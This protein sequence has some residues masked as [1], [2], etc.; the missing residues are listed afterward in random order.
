MNKLL[1]VDLDCML[2]AAHG[3]RL[4]QVKFTG[5]GFA[6][7]ESSPSPF[8]A[9]SRRDAAVWTNSR[10]K[11]K[12]GCVRGFSRGARRR[13]QRLLAKILTDAPLPMMVALTVSDAVLEQSGLVVEPGLW[14]PEPQWKSGG[15]GEFCSQM[16]VWKDNWTKRLH[17]E[18]PQVGWLW[19]LEA[20]PR[21]SGRYK[22]LLVPHLHYLLWGV[23]F[24][25]EFVCTSRDSFF[26]RFRRGRGG[27][28]YVEPLQPGLVDDGENVIAHHYRWKAKPGHAVQVY[29]DFLCA[30]MPSHRVGEAAPDFLV[31]DEIEFREWL[32]VSWYHVVGSH[33]EQHMKAGTSCEEARSLLGAAGYVSKGAGQYVSKLGVWDAAITGRC[34]G[35]GNAA[36]IPWAQVEELKIPAALG[37]QIRRVARHYIEHQIGRKFT[38]RAGCGLTVFCDASRWFNALGLPPPDNPF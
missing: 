24:V 2:R 20:V 5:R 4:F 26:S 10:P 14:T 37:Y 12:R 11:K 34:W 7:G 22:G 3:G 29:W 31:R 36:C 32:S 27:Q 23:P 17:R 9:Q 6:R 19:R 38:V 15:F 8:L 30:S 16:R 33:D 25:D 13:E 1:N 21:K 35:Y 28:E 18:L